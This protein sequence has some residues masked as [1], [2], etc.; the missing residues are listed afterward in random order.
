M[1]RYT[2]FCCIWLDSDAG[3]YD[4]F[5]LMHDNESEGQ[6]NEWTVSDGAS[7]EVEKEN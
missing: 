1:G 4:A 6:P 7:T 5:L 2:V 3:P